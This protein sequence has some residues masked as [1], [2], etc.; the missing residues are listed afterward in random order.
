M[1]SVQIYIYYKFLV[2][3]LN[4]ILKIM[5]KVISKLLCQLCRRS[6]RQDHKRSLDWFFPERS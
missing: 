4:V 1:I 2:K 3:K 6:L 5:H